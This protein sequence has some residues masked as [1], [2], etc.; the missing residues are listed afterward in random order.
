M[1]RGLSDDS[2]SNGHPERRRRPGKTVD[3][4][5]RSQLGFRE[6][7]LGVHSREIARSSGAA[8]VVTCSCAPAI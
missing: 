6:G 8:R 7:R 5:W 3:L 4:G 2:L 1:K